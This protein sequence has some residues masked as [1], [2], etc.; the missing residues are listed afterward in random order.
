MTH[1]HKTYKAAVLQT[2]SH[3]ALRNHVV[4]VLAEFDLSPTEWT[5]IGH[6]FHN[7]SLRFVDI[8]TLL[9]VEPPHITTL[10]DVLQKKKLVQRKEDPNDRR[11]KRI[12]LTKKSEDLVPSIEIELSSRMNL[13]LE[14]IKPEEMATYFR[15]LEAIINNDTKLEEAK[16]K[17]S[18]K[19][20]SLTRATSKP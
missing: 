2:A 3:K 4:E 5:I 9:Q 12:Y 16:S 10:I 6:I 14:G 18:P 13:L 19:S 11:A 8:A 7:E 17:S 1:T 20:E 15:V